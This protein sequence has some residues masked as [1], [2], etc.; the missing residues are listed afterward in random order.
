MGDKFTRADY[1]RKVALR[2]AQSFVAAY[3]P[4]PAAARNGSEQDARQRQ[5]LERYARNGIPLFSEAGFYLP[6]WLYF[7]AG[8]AGLVR[9]YPKRGV[10]LTSLQTQAVKFGLVLI[11]LVAASFAVFVWTFFQTQGR[12]LYPA[13]F[14]IS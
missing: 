14:P 4:H 10:E 6:Y 9:L 5:K 8:I 7:F 12:Y 3:T 11:T 1:V 13:L 2:S